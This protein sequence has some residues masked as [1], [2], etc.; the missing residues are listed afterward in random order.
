MFRVWIH[1]LPKVWQGV[2]CWEGRSPSQ[3][4]VENGEMRCCWLVRIWL[5]LQREKEFSVRERG[6]HFKSRL[7]CSP[8]EGWRKLTQSAWSL[9]YSKNPGPAEAQQEVIFACIFHSV[10]LNKWWATGKETFMN[11]SILIN[12]APNHIGQLCPVDSKVAN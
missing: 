3:L 11:L 12:G 1:F 8:I 10:W 5:T 9:S 6:C 2:L 4:G 7:H